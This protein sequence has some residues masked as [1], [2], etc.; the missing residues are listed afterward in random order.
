MTFYEAAL[1]VL[2]REGKP[3]HYEEITRRALEE[4]LLSHVGRVPC[5]IMRARLLAMAR[6][7]DGKTLAVVEP[8][9]FGLVQ[10]GLVQAREALEAT[11]P[12]LPD[13]KYSLR[14]N[15]RTPMTLAERRAVRE[16]ERTG[17]F[18][19]EDK[20]ARARGKRRRRRGRKGE[21][22][23]DA[24]AAMVHELGDG[25]VDLQYVVDALDRQVALPE[26]FPSKLEGLCELARQ[27][28]E[29][30]ARLG[31]PPRFLLEGDRVTLAPERPA[32]QRPAAAAAGPQKEP[33]PFVLRR[34]AQQAVSKTILAALKEMSHE[35][36]EQILLALA[37][38]HSL[39]DAKVAKRSA[40]G[41]PLFTGMVRFGVS[42]LRCAVRMLLSG[43][44]VRED[45]VDEL[46]ADLQNYS[47]AVGVLLSLGRIPRSVRSRA[48]DMSQKPVLLFDGEALA[49]ACVG[50]RIG[51]RTRFEEVFQFAPE[52]LETPEPNE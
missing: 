44:D 47:A 10:W 30:L 3:L 39:T 16:A 49:D 25:P 12:E 24:L 20:E 40:K 2:G 27:E 35:K 6:R 29:R 45:D 33:A 11:E 7:D 50:S 21:S 42:Q 52:L 22:P 19:A 28:N 37:R 14:P 23:A 32:R 18:Q 41:S 48:E 26:G 4:G 5:D 34:D 51:V 38:S 13:S 31:E 43:R 9:V 36:L 15:E 1:D 17:R 46:R 8:G